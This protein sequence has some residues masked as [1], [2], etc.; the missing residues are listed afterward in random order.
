MDELSEYV[1]QKEQWLNS[2]LK[3]LG[4]TVEG[5]QKVNRIN[6]IIFYGSLV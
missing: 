5:L 4:W 3:K 1:E 6:I 2:V